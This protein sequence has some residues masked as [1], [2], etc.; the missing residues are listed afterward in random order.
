MMSF[1]ETSPS[2]L[3]FIHNKVLRT[4]FM[5]DTIIQT[6]ILLSCTPSLLYVTYSIYFLLQNSLTIILSYF[7]AKSYIYI[8]LETW[9][10]DCKEFKIN[11]F[12]LLPKCRHKKKRIQQIQWGYNNLHQKRIHE[13]CKSFKG[14]YYVRNETIVEDGQIFHWI[15]R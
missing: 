3:V 2:P 15:I 6:P 13:G 4:V 1:S 12:N 7:N 9:K 5:F 11:G 8:S 10:G 14:R